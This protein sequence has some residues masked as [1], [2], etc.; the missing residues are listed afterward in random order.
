MI[1]AIYVA[2]SHNGSQQ[3]LESVYVYAGKGIVGDRHY[4]HR[5]ESGL[6]ITLVEI[7]EIERFNHDHGQTISESD[8]RRNIITRGV[9]LNDLLGK[10]FTIGQ[11]TLLGTE[12][13]EPCSKLGKQLSKQGLTSAEVVK[14]FLNKGGLRCDVLSNGK[15]EVGMAIVIEA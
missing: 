5:K 11:V 2:E 1:K 15:L 10:R 4:G 9:R 6:N 7:E 8:T 12:L 14:G 3:S 13:C